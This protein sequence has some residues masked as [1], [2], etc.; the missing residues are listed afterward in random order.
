VEVEEKNKSLKKHIS[1][2]NK[3]NKKLKKKQAYL[4]R[5]IGQISAGDRADETLSFK[6][7]RIVFLEGELARKKERLEELE[8]KIHALYRTLSRIAYF[9]VAKRFRNLGWIEFEYKNKI[10]DIQ[11][12]DILFIDD[13]NEFSKKA[14]NSL[15]GKVRILVTKKK[16]S[17]KNRKELTAHFTIIDSENIDFEEE[18]FFVFIKKKGFEKA[19]RS[20]EVLKGIVAEYKSKRK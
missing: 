10:L 3:E 17:A 1:K 15:K 9:V 18:R 8:N 6:E 11:S 14:V 5:K 7:E 12:N 19:R 16:L 20:K 13:A 4:S 2:S